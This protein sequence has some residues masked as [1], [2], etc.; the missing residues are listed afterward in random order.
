MGYSSAIVYN[1]VCPS[2]TQSATG[3]TIFI[4]DVEP[5]EYSLYFSVCP[6]ISLFICLSG[7]LSVR[8]PVSSFCFYGQFVLVC[9]H[10]PS[11]L[12]SFQFLRSSEE[13]KCG[14][15]TCVPITECTEM[16]LLINKVKMIYHENLSII[17]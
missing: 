16:I 9:S 5:N 3:V 17:I 11:Y 14:S 13:D 1:L 10:L 6:S 8:L 12:Q 4:L 15:K 7:C 2:L